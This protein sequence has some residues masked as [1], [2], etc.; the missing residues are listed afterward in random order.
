MYRPKFSI[1]IPTY[2]SSLY[3]E[4]TFHSILSQNYDDFE[5]IC[6]DDC[7]TDNTCSIIEA[8]IKKDQR[9]R[10]IKH[11]K[12]QGPGALR[13]E[14]VSEAI[15]DWILFC[16]SDDW[17]E[18]NLFNNL[19]NIIVSETDINIIAFRYNISLNQKNKIP[20]DWFDLGET[21]IKSVTN[22]NLM[23]CTSLWN[24]C[25]KKDFINVAQL[26]CCV[27]NRSGEEI[28]FYICALLKA[29]KFYYL[30]DLGYNW[31][32]RENSLSHSKEKDADFLD[33]VWDMIGI[34]RNE[35]KRLYLY[36]DETYYLYTQ[37]IL[38]W[39]IDEKF[40]FSKHY[41]SYYNKCRYYFLQHSLKKLPPFWLYA[42]K[43]LK[44]R[45]K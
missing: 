37:T 7:S 26:K 35:L 15:G 16:D 31:R 28:P 39:H 27:S 18:P 20:A 38:R 44:R 3:I 41:I 40:S 6:L 9:F 12:N 2:N 5:I 24:K 30:S 4:E 8:Y 23:L 33:G 10:L 29:K 19:V 45:R 25:W 43:K 32:T 36:T 22:D 1:I 42:Y 14:G 34:L 21:N 17:F 11:F 13:N